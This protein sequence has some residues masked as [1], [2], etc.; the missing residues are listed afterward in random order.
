MKNTAGLLQQLR[1]L[2]VPVNFTW[3]KLLFDK[4][5]KNY[6]VPTLWMVNSLI[7]YSVF[8]FSFSRQPFGYY[9]IWGLVIL[10]PLSYYSFIFLTRRIH[11]PAVIVILLILLLHQAFNFYF[12]SYFAA[13]E[14]SGIF[15]RL[16]DIVGARS[17]SKAALSPGLLFITYTNS[18]FSNLPV[19]IFGLLYQ[20]AIRV[21]RNQKLQEENLRLELNYLRSQISPHLLFNLLNSLYKTVLD[22]EEA[23]TMIIRIKN[24]LS[25]SLY[26]TERNLIT[27]KKEIEFLESYTAL[28]SRRIPDKKKLSLT[29]ECGNRDQLTIVPLILINYVE[30]AIKHGLHSTNASSWVEIHLKTEGNVLHFSCK[31]QINPQLQNEADNG[32]KGIGLDNTQRRLKHYYNNRHYLTISERGGIYD[33]YLRI[34]LDEN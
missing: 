9:Y 21:F 18:F 29:V 1:S 22:N 33:V 19:I 27:L 26:E 20:L 31:N 24:F 12:I 16:L 25:Y 2:R 30:N 28:E 32:E 8:S 10:S 4:K 3:D 15:T 17:F 7:I 6:L 23:T 13:L 11:L 14:G 5:A 34:S